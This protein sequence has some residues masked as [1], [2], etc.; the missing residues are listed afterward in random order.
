MLE[1]EIKREI[2]E[3][4]RMNVRKKEREGMGRKVAEVRMNGA[5]IN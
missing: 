4:V 5:T 3:E 2:V 1:G